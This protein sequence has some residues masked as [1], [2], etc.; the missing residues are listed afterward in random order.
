[1]RLL[2]AYEGRSIERL[3]SKEWQRHEGENKK[4]RPTGRAFFTFSFFLFHKPLLYY[5]K[6]NIY[7]TPISVLTLVAR[8]ARSFCISSG[9]YFQ[10]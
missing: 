1:M 7:L 4:A 6:I 5:Y 8:L 10:Q 3:A 2:Q 9:I